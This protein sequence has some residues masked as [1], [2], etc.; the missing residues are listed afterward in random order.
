MTSAIGRG[1]L[2]RIVQPAIDI[3]RRGVRFTDFYPV[4][5]V[6][7]L[8]ATR[9][10]QT[11]YSN[12]RI[13]LDFRRVKTHICFFGSEPRRKLEGHGYTT[14]HIGKWH[15]GLPTKNRAKPTPSHHGFGLVHYLEQRTPSHKNP[16]F[17]S[18]RTVGWSL[19]GYS[20]NW[21]RRRR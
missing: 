8:R 2:R 7:H 4:G 10:R 5:R 6:Y 13:Q 19:E 3:G 15:L 9:D 21:L 1:L 20:V 12:G 16:N 18:E 17:H 14:A 11:P